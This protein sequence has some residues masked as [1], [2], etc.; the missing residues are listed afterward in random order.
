[1]KSLRAILAS[2]AAAT[3][4]VVA[5]LS[6]SRELSDGVGAALGGAAA[7]LVVGVQ[8]WRRY[9]R[10]ALTLAAETRAAATG[11]DRR[12][13]SI[14]GSAL[15]DLAR[16]V[17]RLAD[18]NAERGD[19]LAASTALQSAVTDSV[20]E[21]LLAIDSRNEILLINGVAQELLRV[22]ERAP[23]PADWLPRDRALREA[24]AA[25]QRGEEIRDVEFRVGDRTLAVRAR[26]MIRVSDSAAYGC[27][28][29]I[30]DLTPSKRLEAVRRD[31]VANVSHELRTPLTI[32]SGVAETLDD[33]QMPAEAR[34]RFLA[35]VSTNARRMQRIVD[36]L[37]DL[38]RIE[39][40][41]WLPNPSDLDVRPLAGEVFAPLRDEAARKGVTLSLSLDA[42][43]R[44]Y[45]DPTALRQVLSNLGENALRHTSSGQVTIFTALED[46]DGDGRPEGIWVGV[47]D[48]GTG[49]P[50]EHISRIFERF[51]R[52]DPSRSREAGGTGLGLAIV[53]HL[54]EAHGGRVQADSA[55]GVGTTI[56]A[57]FPAASDGTREPVIDP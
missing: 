24:I 56:A 53:K 2:G 48:T 57:L 50:E 31:F 23:F 26:P 36:D 10:P 12:R 42:G 34:R 17:Q 33:E 6:M 54:A 22:N 55:L 9:T 51:Y 29:V 41:G 32:I 39:S 49:I 13:P 37:L 3:L 8:L 11:D 35:M 45:A 30:S 38:S 43:E 21:G 52:A 19:A 4:V 18:Q 20:G 16:A 46:R 47:R 7:L 44:V 27:V 40:G 25:A 28:L 1:V 15:D 14:T 5:V